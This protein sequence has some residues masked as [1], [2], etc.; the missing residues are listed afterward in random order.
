MSLFADDV[1]TVIGA[2][3]SGSSS[4]WS[5]LCGFFMYERLYNTHLGDFECTCIKAGDSE[6]KGLRVEEPIGGSLDG[7]FLSLSRNI[8][9]E[10]AKAWLP[11]VHWEVREKRGL[12]DRIRG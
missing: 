10:S 12:G 9:K 2:G 3:Q 7:I 4:G 8:G 11:L 1:T 5:V 6:S